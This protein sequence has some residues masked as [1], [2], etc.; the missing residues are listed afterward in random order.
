MKFL[1]ERKFDLS[2]FAISDLHLSF[3]SDKP[4][5][6]FDGWEDYVDRLRK[7]WK[8]NIKNEDT[9]VIA[10]DISWAISLRESFDDFCFLQSLPGKKI[11]MRGNHDYW[12]STKRKVEM[13][14][15]ENELSSI[16]VLHNSAI[17]IGDYCICGA[18]SWMYPAKSPEDEKIL[19]REIGRLRIS[20]DLAIKTNLTPIVFLHYPPIC[21][22][23]VNKEIIN[24]LLENKI[25]ECYFGHVHGKSA[26]GRVFLGKYK[27]IYFKLLSADSLGF[28]PV[29]IKCF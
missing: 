7:N 26:L 22:F 5:D 24:I 21:G 9:V 17:S 1:Q 13:F 16:F 15:K 12:W 20:V 18:R 8:K 4:M 28:N 23:D 14:L 29:E 3:K 27:G 25:K 11:I 10:G 2:I 19:K 6:I